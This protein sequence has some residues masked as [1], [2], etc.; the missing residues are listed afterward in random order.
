[1]VSNCNHRCQWVLSSPPLS[2]YS[3]QWIQ[4]NKFISAFLTKTMLGTVPQISLW[5]IWSRYSHTFLH[6]HRCE[7]HQSQFANAIWYC[8]KW[9]IIQEDGQSGHW[10]GEI[11]WR[12]EGKA[13]LLS[14]DSSSILH[15]APLIPTGK[16]PFHWN[17]QEWHWNPQE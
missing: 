5:T 14:L 2:S 13:Y 8:K 12:D 3:T 4:I 7:A 16:D 11:C 10:W 15:H 9:G 1:M 17:P 6:M